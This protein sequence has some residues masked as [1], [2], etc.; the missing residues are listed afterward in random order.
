L[1]DGTPGAGH[2]PLLANS[3]AIDRGND[4]VCSADPVLNTDQLGQLRVGPCDIGAIEFEGALTI[5][6]DVRPRRDSPNR[7]NPNSNRNINVALLSSAGFD[8]TLIDT[9]TVR[10]GCNGVKAAPILIRRRDVNR[11]GQRDL[12]LRFQIQ[13]LGLECGASSL[14]LTGQ[15]TAGHP[16]TG[17]SP[18]ITTGC[19]Q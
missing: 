11:D 9:N 7:I 10:F 18:I 5:V 12:V 14:I 16:I 13:D 1:D 4:E 19:R 6:I 17:E 15:N 8:A 3:P 2:F